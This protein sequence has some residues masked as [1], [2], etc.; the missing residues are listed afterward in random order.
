[1]TTAS[2]GHTTTCRNIAVPR[3][4]MVLGTTTPP[5]S[6]AP[7]GTGPPHTHLEEYGAGH[8]DEGDGEQDY[9]HGVPEHLSAA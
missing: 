5:P 6:S 1:M 2:Q 3:K 8:D 7:P 4:A 9:N